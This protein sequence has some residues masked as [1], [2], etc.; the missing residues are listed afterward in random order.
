MTSTIIV[1]ILFAAIILYGAIKSFKNIRNNSC[2][3]C[4]GGCSQSQR[5]SCKKMR[6]E[7]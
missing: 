7:K 6:L 3:G 4:S 5:N 2:P 1:G